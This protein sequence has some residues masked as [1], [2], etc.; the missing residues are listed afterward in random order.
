MPSAHPAVTLLSI[1]LPV[2]AVAVFCLAGLF[3]WVQFTFSHRP[4]S[5]AKTAGILREADHRKNVT[6]PSRRGSLFIK[7]LTKALYIYTV[8]GVEY[9]IR[10][11]FPA[12]KRQTPKFV[13][14]VYIKRFPRF[15]HMDDPGSFSDMRYGLWGALLMVWGLSLAVIAV[16][17]LT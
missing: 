2:A 12:T 9:G 17:L 14:V 16:A 3:L 11:E 6:I 10:D 1:L 4:K 8:D 7:N 13:P 5:T 15:A